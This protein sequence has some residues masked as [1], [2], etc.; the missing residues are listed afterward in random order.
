M[1]EKLFTEG[2]EVLGRLFG[3]SGDNAMQQAINNLFA[4]PVPDLTIDSFQNVYSIT[5]ALGIMLGMAFGV[6]VAVFYLGRNHVGIGTVLP[7]TA[8]LMFVGQV[9]LVGLLTLPVTGTLLWF[10]DKGTHAVS[11]LPGADAQNTWMR[12]M[13]DILVGFAPGDVIMSMIMNAATFFSAYGLT[14]G[15]ALLTIG[16][17][18]ALIGTPVFYAF[19]IVGKP[20]YILWR[21]WVS[22]LIV[23]ITAKFVIALVLAVGNAIITTLSGL[24]LASVESGDAI[25]AAFTLLCGALAPLVVL[26]ATY[27]GLD[28]HLPPAVVTGRVS[29]TNEGG[30]HSSTVVGL[31]SAGIGALAARQSAGQSGDVTINTPGSQRIRASGALS[32]GA[33]TLVSKSHPVAAAVV[34][35][36]SLIT[37]SSGQAAQRKAS[38]PRAIAPSAL[39]ITPYAPPAAPSSAS[40][41][42]G[43]R[44]PV[45][46]LSTT[47]PTSVVHD[48]I[49]GTPPT[50]KAPEG[51]D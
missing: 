35:G 44:S 9:F 30:G 50:T 13:I 28:K 51:G 33:A 7:F 8:R 20:G 22:L 18:P 37:G 1:I 27:K 16:V 36:G 31:A 6:G 17:F 25:L 40:M 11:A 47:T 23:T 34:M 39:D 12:S 45:Q 42:E 19:S 4:Q 38:T 2:F 14:W 3:L 48:H 24:N 46:S 32:K 10:F 29:S 15:T 41:P 21:I 43:I 26:V 49:T 5:W